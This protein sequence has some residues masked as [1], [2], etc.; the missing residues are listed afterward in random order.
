MIEIKRDYPPRDISPEELEGYNGLSEEEQ[1][2]LEMYYAFW[3]KIR[4]H[5]MFS[6]VIPPSLKDKF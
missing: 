6:E 2:L 1:S 4:E 3:E 5:P